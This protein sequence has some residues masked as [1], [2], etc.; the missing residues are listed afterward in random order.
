MKGII[1]AGGK[2][3][4]LYPITQVVC[5]QLL[6]IYD[7]PLIYYPLS[8]LMLAG[9]REIL[10]IS[11]PEDIQHFQ[12]LFKDGSTLGLSISYKVQNAPNGLAEA[13]ILGEAFIGDDSVCLV[14]GDNI[15]YGHGLTGML[16]EAAKIEDGAVIFGY[17]V[18]DPN[19]YGVVEFDANNKAISIEEKPKDPKSDYAVVGLY[20]YDNS[21]I[22]IAKSVKP[23]ARGELEITSVNEAYLK[24]KKLQVKILSR[25]FAWLDTGTFTSMLEATEFVKTIEDRQDLKISCIE[26]I[27]FHKG[28][29]DKPQLIKLAEPLI[30]SGYGEYLLKVAKSKNPG[31]HN[32]Q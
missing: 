7:K 32:L 6:P 30:K 22:D 19:R 29:I 18:K 13:F 28:F 11:T 4:R 23:S 8:T 5:K 3:T 10:I 21:V 15:F 1:L 31:N 17:K 16:M 27:A 25:G 14:L 26:E 9:I 12:D 24:R 20:F 2:G